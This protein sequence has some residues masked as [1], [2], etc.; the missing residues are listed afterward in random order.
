MTPQ[1]LN[2][3]KGSLSAAFEDTED[4]LTID[5]ESEIAKK[6]MSALLIVAAQKYFERRDFTEL[7]KTLLVAIGLNP[8]HFKSPVAMDAFKVVRYIYRKTRDPQS[9]FLLAPTHQK[10]LNEFFKKEGSVHRKFVLPPNYEDDPASVAARIS[11]STQ[12]KQN[13]RHHP[14]RSKSSEDLQRESRN[15]D[16]HMQKSD[17]YQ[18]PIP[19]RKNDLNQGLSLP[20]VVAHPRRTRIP[21][22]TD[23]DDDITS[24]NPNQ[25][26]QIPRITANPDVVAH[27]RKTK[28]PFINDDDGI[29]PANRMVSN[30]NKSPAFGLVSSDSNTLRSSEK[31]SISIDWSPN[32]QYVCEKPKNTRIPFLERSVLEIGRNPDVSIDFTNRSGL[33][34]SHTDQR[35]IDVDTITGP[36]N[37]ELKKFSSAYSFPNQPHGTGM[38][39]NKTNQDTSIYS[40]PGQQSGTWMTNLNRG[41]TVD[42]KPWQQGGR[43]IPNHRVVPVFCTGI[44][45]LIK[46]ETT[47]NASNKS[48]TDSSSKELRGVGTSKTNKKR[49]STRNQ[50]RGSKSQKS[51]FHYE[52]SV[53]CRSNQR[54]NSTKFKS[55][56]NRV[57]SISKPY[58]IRNSTKRPSA[59]DESSRPGSWMSNWT[60]QVSINSTLYKERDCKN[61]ASSSDLE[62]ISV[63]CVPNE[64]SRPRMRNSGENEDIWIPHTSDSRR[65]LEDDDVICL[66]QKRGFS[67][68][69]SYRS[70]DRNRSVCYTCGQSKLSGSN[71]RGCNVDKRRRSRSP[72]PDKR[73]SRSRSSD[74]RRKQL[75]SRSH[76]SS[77]DRRRNSKSRAPN[78]LCSRRMFASQFF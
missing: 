20:D 43:V 39:T 21:F 24:D 62:V 37:F 29:V 9:S 48:P 41:T 67:K 72:N 63:N 65:E 52:D 78:D 15:R 45:E 69:R 12:M 31:Q 18:L 3:Q 75:G 2:V 30:L 34:K 42:P 56:R 55:C 51:S 60:R 50:R 11:L 36:G 54:R 58:E 47:I 35:V 5:P 40:T 61:Q 23:D 73:R 38:V 46:T 17:P 25:P 14:M 6:Q 53:D 22:I 7:Y 19:I 13:K 8:S 59:A 28:I 66:Y 77:R 64:H 57:I 26:F 68:S 49:D 10:V 16:I 70:D 44:H 33:Y 71:Y 4:S 74:Y 76:F 32:Q 27:P 1:P